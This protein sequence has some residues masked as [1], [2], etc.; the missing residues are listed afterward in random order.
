[1]NK[2][3][4]NSGR[5]LFLSLLSSNVQ[6]S[7]RQRRKASGERLTVE[8]FGLQVKCLPLCFP[9]HIVSVT[10]ASHYPYY[11]QT[12]VRDARQRHA[13]LEQQNTVIHTCASRTEQLTFRG[14]AEPSTRLLS[15]SFNFLNSFRLCDLMCKLAETVNI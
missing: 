9:H 10:I 5:A 2:W 14:H 4:Q 13:A 6:P 1:M 3:L 15:T 11:V 8:G 7:D 12:N